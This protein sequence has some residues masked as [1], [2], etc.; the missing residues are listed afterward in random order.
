M[1]D[2]ESDQ[3]ERNTNLVNW[4]IDQKKLSRSKENTKYWKTFYDGL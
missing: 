2:L 3:R 4:N 1:N